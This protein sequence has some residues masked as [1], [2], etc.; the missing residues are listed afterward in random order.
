M[1]SSICPPLSGTRREAVPAAD[2]KEPETAAH[3][4]SLMSRSFGSIIPVPQ[5][6][7]P[8]YLGYRPRVYVR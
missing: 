1:V 8:M 5:L 4:A 6:I 2:N 7:M 3:Y